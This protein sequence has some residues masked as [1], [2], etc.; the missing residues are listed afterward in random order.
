MKNA[1]VRHAV[2]YVLYRAATGAVRT[3][4]H[5]SLPRWG[6]RLGRLGYRLRHRQR[7]LAL[8]NLEWVFP[9]KTAEERDAI[10]RESFAQFGSY[11]LQIPSVARFGP[12][13]L[14]DRFEIEGWEHLEGVLSGDGSDG[15]SGERGA[16]LTTGHFGCWEMAMYPLALRMGNFVGIAREM[17]NP[18]IHAH[19]CDR[20]ERFGIEI[21]NKKGV[22]HRMLNAYRRGKRL[23]ILIDQHVHPNLGIQVPFFGRSAWTSP[24]LAMLSL[25]TGAPVVPFCC[26]PADE[27][28]SYRLV[29]HPPIEPE[30]EGPDAVQE[31]TRRYLA[32]VEDDIRWRPE[33]WVWMHRRWREN[34]RRT[35]PAA[36]WEVRPAPAE[37]LRP[38]AR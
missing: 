1:P 3:L 27:P 16:F 24:I 15:S 9:E 5:E 6:K 2:E 18:H 22:A 13:E 26:V 21:M 36:K 4:P 28:G 10:A 20:R 19:L 30:G 35:G 23:A 7:E 31:M 25:R 12:E 38:E 8:R 32:V 33:L 14:L 11:L 34:A 29:I 17:D 37:H